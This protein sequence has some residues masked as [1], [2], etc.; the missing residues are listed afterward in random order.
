[1]LKG[2]GEGMAA[3]ARGAA[4]IPALLAFTLA[5]VALGFA[6]KM[7]AEGMGH[8][9]E[10]VKEMKAGDVAKMAG[11]MSLMGLA[12]I[13][14]GVGLA[15]F[16]AAALVAA[17]GLIALG[18]ALK[19]FGG[20]GGMNLPDVMN[21]LFSQFNFNTAN[22]TGAVASIDASLEF[23]GRFAVLGA[24]MVGLAAGSALATGVDAL[25]G[26]FGIDSPMQMLAK[27]GQGVA[28]TL[29]SLMFTFGRMAKSAAMN[30]VD[31][32]LRAVDVSGQFIARLG[33]MMKSV[34]DLG[35]QAKGLEDGFFTDGPLQRL[36]AKG[37]EF[38]KTVAG[39]MGQAKLLM[40]PSL[41]LAT[42]A[43]INTVSNPTVIQSDAEVKA[44]E[45]ANG[46]LAQILTAI[47]T[48]SP[49][50]L[51]IGAPAGG[52]FVSDVAGGRH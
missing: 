3:M 30:S 51:A 14:L 7:T 34:Q 13:P 41:K 44:L 29:V 8:F 42:S 28:D 9:M 18:A 47:Q 21:A 2:I 36:N 33:P 5:V 37:S 49:V 38:F 6:F 25:L 24:T 19:I 50:K 20:L 32:V 23:M 4:G 31:G 17:P 35:T 46:L 16:G 39:L 12:F 52:G 10:S 43:E 45:I 40:E 1:V 48:G 15:V 26:L 27:Q 11:A 22:V